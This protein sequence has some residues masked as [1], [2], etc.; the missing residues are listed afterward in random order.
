MWRWLSLAIP[1]LLLSLEVAAAE[2]FDLA[3]YRDLKERDT[4]RLEF[5]LG[6]MYDS[7]F[8]AQE[9]IDRATVCASPLPVSGAQLMA[10]VDYEIANPSHP[11]RRTY[12]D[13]D[14]VAFVL[15]NALKAENVCR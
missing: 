11:T 15:V 3:D 8:Y 5:V 14:H 9:S 12:S 6:A 13:N 4:A 7:V 1:A 10:M 2:W